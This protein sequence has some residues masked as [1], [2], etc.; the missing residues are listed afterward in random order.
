MHNY[1][2]VV[3]LPFSDGPRDVP[4]HIAVLLKQHKIA[5]HELT[6]HQ[7]MQRLDWMNADKALNDQFNKIRDDHLRQF[8]I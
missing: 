5:T 7:A 4:E 2:T 3:P 1:P 6:Y 8:G